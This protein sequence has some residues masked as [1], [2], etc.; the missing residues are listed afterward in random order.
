V[1]RGGRPFLYGLSKKGCFIT[2]HKMDGGLNKKRADIQG[3]PTETI[4][5]ATKKRGGGGGGGFTNKDEGRN[6]GGI[7]TFSDGDEN[8]ENA[9][10]ERGRSGGE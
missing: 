3:Y 7:E 6:S 10:G 9:K 4:R 1:E 2:N 5:K 8:V